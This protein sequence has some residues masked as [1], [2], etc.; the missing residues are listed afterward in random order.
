MQLFGTKSSVGPSLDLKQG[1]GLSLTEREAEVLLKSEHHST[2]HKGNA[3]SC[4]DFHCWF[5]TM[6]EFKSVYHYSAQDVLIN[7]HRT[8]RWGDGQSGWLHHPQPGC[9]PGGAWIISH[10]SITGYALT[11]DTKSALYLGRDFRGLKEAESSLSAE[12]GLIPC[13]TPSLHEVA[14][15]GATKSFCRLWLLATCLS[16]KL[17]NNPFMDPYF[18]YPWSRRGISISRIKEIHVINDTQ[19]ISFAPS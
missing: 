19:Q 8:G 1:H 12:V 15:L 11:P 3:W 9:A 6:H 7:R 2:L 18:T 5:W 14:L 17:F 16:G 4:D 10:Q 13:P